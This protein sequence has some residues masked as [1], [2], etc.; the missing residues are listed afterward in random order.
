MNQPISN[1][2]LTNLLDWECLNETQTELSTEHF[3]QAARLSQSINFSQ[4]RWQVYINILAVLGFQEWL[5]ERAPDLQLSTEQSSIWQPKY[6]N[7][8]PAACNILIDNF[9]ICIITGSNLIDEHSIPFAVFDIPRFTAHFYILMQ[10]IEEKEQVAVTGFISYE[11][12]CRYQQTAQLPIQPDWTYSIPQS[13]FNSQSNAL[14]LNLRCLSADAIQLPVIQDNS[15]IDNTALKQKLSNIE[16]RLQNQ[17]IWQLLTV[18]EGIDL[19]NNS[20]LVNWVHQTIK[21]VPIQPLIN[22]GN[23]LNNKIDEITHELGW[24]LMPSL[25]LSELRS[26]ENFEQVRTGLEQK[27]VHIPAN[28]KGAYRDLECNEN[29][30]LRLYAITWLLNENSDNPEWVLLIVLGSQPQ[31]IMPETLKLE[32]RDE[33]ELLFEQEVKDT[34][35]S[36]LYAQ[37]VGNWGER[38]W[39]NIIVDED[40]LIEIP[41]F[42]FELEKE[43]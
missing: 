40:T 38:F 24:V 22:V 27:G 41:P 20:E 28:A 2:E 7:L 16:S 25:R 36:I 26:L 33:T 21:P 1:S 32:V 5:K 39:I 6:A 43:F 31:K 4:Q 34:T 11:E 10:V 37:L 29:T 12:Y 9:K 35:Q 19:L 42:G 13:W 8:L 30:S 14:L 17:N 18:Q 15:E 23:W 3:H